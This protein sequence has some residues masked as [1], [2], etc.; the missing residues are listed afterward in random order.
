MSRSP[1][2]ILCLTLLIAGCNPLA[3][4]PVSTLDQAPTPRETSPVSGPPSPTPE[5]TATN[6]ATA[7]PTSTSTATP[8]SAFDPSRLGDLERDITYCTVDGVELKMDLYFPESMDGPWPAAVYVHGGA[9][10]AGDKTA[11]AGYREVPELAAHGYLV[12]SINYRLAPRYRFPAQI[13]D[14]KCAIRH[15][16][17][18]AA[19][20][21]LDP[22][23]IGA[24]GSSAGGHLVA[25]LGLT[26]PSHGLEGQGGY[27]KQSSR[28]Q[29]VVDLFGP[30]DIRLGTDA[31]PILESVFGTSDT[32]A[33]ILEIASPVVYASADDPPFLILHGTEDPVVPPEQ[34]QALYEAL[35]AAGVPVTL[36]LVENAGHGFASVNGAIDPSREEITQLIVEFFDSELK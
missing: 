5:P 8:E 18:H 24:W 7:I 9:W 11:G 33:P 14:V 17:A 21:N 30:A 12:A 36:V 27:P 6:T 16:R 25:L 29:A 23:R 3:P 26:D 13:E 19:S 15:L 10:Q 34:S 35:T 22:Q 32:S 28:V 4:S 31:D 1:L 20:Y 2:I